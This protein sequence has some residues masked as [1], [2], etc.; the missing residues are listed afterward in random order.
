MLQAKALVARGVDLRQACREARLFG[1]TF[2]RRRTGLA[3]FGL[4][5]LVRFPVLLSLA[6]RTIKS[7]AIDP[8]AVLEELVR[9]MLRA[10]AAGG[11][12]A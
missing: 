1:D 4:D 7:R 5:E 6:D 11:A 2:E 10:R 12:T 3:R 8:G 9:S